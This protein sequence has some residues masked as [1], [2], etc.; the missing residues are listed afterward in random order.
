VGI[1]AMAGRSKHTPHPK[2][3]AVGARAPAASFAAPGEAP[4]SLAAAAMPN[5]NLTA[6]RLHPSAMPLVAGTGTR[7]WMDA[8]PNRFAYRCLPMLI[9]NQAGWYVLTQH[10]VTVTW[11]GSEAS[12]GLRIECTEG[13]PP[14]MAVSSFGSGILTWTVPYLFRTPPG[15]NMLVRG[16]ANWPKDGIAPLEGIVETDWSEATFTM[17]WKV[18][19]PNNP[20]SF[21]VGE[22]IA[23]I[24]PQP[25]GE[26]ELFRPDIRDIAAHPELHDAYEIWANSRRQFNEDLHKTDSEARKQGW[27]KHYAQG[28]TVTEVRSPAHQSKLA[29][30]GFA[31]ASGGQTDRGKK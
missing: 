13:E 10:A 31:E 29:L 5:L 21:A 3:R 23:M 9:A 4:S 8:T 1:A 15:Y 14:C 28:K 18:T 22:P 6:Y 16:P 12:S 30:H 20:V 11:D 7:D 19:R 27:Q 2:S 24:V 17:N 26:L 25:R